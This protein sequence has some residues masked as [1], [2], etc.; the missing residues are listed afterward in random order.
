MNRSKYDKDSQCR[1]SRSDSVDLTVDTRSSDG[2]PIRDVH[3]G[4]VAS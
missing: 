1:A 3:D 2:M 4:R